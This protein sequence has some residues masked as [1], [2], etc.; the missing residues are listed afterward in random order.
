MRKLSVILLILWMGNSAKAQEDPQFAHN[1]YNNVFTNPGSAGMT[2]GRICADIINRNT[3]LGFEG[4]PK[5][6]LASVHT[7]VKKLKG[8][9]GLSI[10]DDRLGF[11]S[12]F[13]AKLAY[14]YHKQT[15]MGQLGLG[16]ETGLINRAL[17]GSW[18]APD[19][20]QGDAL[21]PESPARKM[22]LDLGVGAYLKKGNTYHLGVSVSHIQNPKI[23]FSDST[24]SF[25]RRHYFGTA[26]YNLRLFNSPIE[27]KP[28]VFIKYDGTKVQYSGNLTAQYNKKFS[29]GVSY[30]NKDAIVGIV[31]FELMPDLHVS[32]AYELSVSRL[33]TVNKG[34]H[35]IYVG[36]CLDLY[37]PQRNY[38]YKDVRYL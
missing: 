13:R 12:D 22:F 25:L 20:V 9:V 2:N 35:E 38:K 33:I 31:G 37:K 6:T 21:I 30:R 16:L 5:T 11:Y 23:A 32:Y 26:G 7:S 36:Y 3:W 1:M 10:V 28:S 29:L 15:T 8:G 27:L 14:S 24:A 34:T 19:G 17:D 18:Q 4:A